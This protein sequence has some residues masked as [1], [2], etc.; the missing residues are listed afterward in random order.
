ML[1][2]IC[3]VLLIIGVV[4]MFIV[5]DNYIIGSAFIFAVGV[6]GTAASVII[7]CINYIGSESYVAKNQVRYD[8]F[9]Y[10]YENHFYDNDNDIGKKEL[11]S[12][13]QSWNEDLAWYKAN[14]RNLWIGIYIPNVYDQFD[15]I[16]LHG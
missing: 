13:I 8:S 14:Q 9:T 10:Q 3:L 4:M 2:W 5:D 11:M 16:E 6:L 15:F 12:E 7:L 1:F